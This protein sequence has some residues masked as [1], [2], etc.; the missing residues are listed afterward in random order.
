MILACTELP[1]VVEAMEAACEIQGRLPP[2]LKLV[3]PAE[4]LA[5]ALLEHV[6]P[7]H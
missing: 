5:A 2:Q 6:T 7:L 1:L 3:D 4:L